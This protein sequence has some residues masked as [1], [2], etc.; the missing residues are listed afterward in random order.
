LYESE[1]GTLRLAG[2]LPD[3]TPADASIAATGV[4]ALSLAPHTISDG[5]DG[6]SRVFFTVP[7]DDGTNANT[8]AQAGNLYMRV[9]HAQTVQ[10]NAS[11][12]ASA[13]SFAPAQYL[14]ASSDGRRVFFMTQQALT[15]DA[16]GNGARAIYMYDASKP[17]SA[18]DNLTL[19][20]PPGFAEGLIGASDDGHYAYMVVE[21][22]LG[23][24]IFVWHDGQIKPI[25]PAPISLPL[26]EMYTD[27]VSNQ[28]LRQA[29]VTP[30]GRHLVFVSDHGAALGGNPDGICTEYAND[31]CRVLYVYSADTDQLACVSCDPGGAAPKYNASVVA[32]FGIGGGDGAFLTNGGARVTSH[33]SRAISADGR[34]VFFSTAEALAP[35]DTN[36]VT[37]AYEYDTETAKVSL[38][39]SGTSKFGSWFVETGEAGRDAFIVTREAL[40][41]SDIDQAYD[42]YDVRAG[43]GFPEPSPK[44]PAPCSGET[45]QG[46]QSASPGAAPVGS[47]LEG[48]GNP[49]RPR[50][51]PEG[52]RRAVTRSGKSRCAKKAQHHHS[53]RRQSRTADNHGRAGR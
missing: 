49:K 13:D 12:R 25:G 30:D 26:S 38:L 32:A 21:G 3:G 23:L 48:A 28:T 7:T 42:I 41:D 18:S 2:I 19:I 52:R 22:A 11:E 16:P 8:F 51:C 14:D 33:Q 1:D 44:Q 9:D 40:V 50:R 17:D 34:F 47:G 46:A 20:S 27:G 45:C 36:G 39:S 43:G 15:D 35:R 10:L 29:R 37:D 4:L 24:K 5:S 31:S 6:H 53:H